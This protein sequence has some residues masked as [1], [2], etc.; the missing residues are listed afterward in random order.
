MENNIY[1]NYVNMEHA[2]FQSEWL[3]YMSFVQNDD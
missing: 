3:C 1:R 2:S